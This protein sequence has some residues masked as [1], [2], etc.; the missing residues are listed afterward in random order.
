MVFFARQKCRRSSP[1]GTHDA[2][3][4]LAVEGGAAGDGERLRTIQIEALQGRVY[5]PVLRI[6]EALGD[7]RSAE[8][9]G[10]RRTVLREITES[11]EL[12]VAVELPDVVQ[13]AA[14]ASP[15]TTS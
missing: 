3:A 2:A 1:A 15:G 8:K 14:S 12:P 13:I 4:V 9:R 11:R 10:L 7:C 5:L 6:D